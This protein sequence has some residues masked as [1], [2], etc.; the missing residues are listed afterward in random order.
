MQIT[1]NVS[2]ENYLELLRSNADEVRSLF[3]DLLINVTNFF[4]DTD[5]FMMLQETVIP[6][7][8]EGRDAS[9]TIRV[10]GTWLCNG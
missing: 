8:F 9:D 5:A 6:K 3:R 1:Q 2:I 4:R 10:L 7:L